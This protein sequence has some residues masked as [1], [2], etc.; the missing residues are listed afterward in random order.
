MY[1]IILHFL[2]VIYFTQ[3]SKIKFKEAL[4]LLFRN[5]LMQAQAPIWFRLRCKNKIRTT[6]DVSFSHV[7]VVQFHRFFDILWII[8]LFWIFME[9]PNLKNR[10]ILGPNVF[11]SG[12]NISLEVSFIVILTNNTK[13]KITMLLGRF[14]LIFYLNYEHVLFKTEKK[15][16]VDFL[17][18]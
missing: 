4:S 10:T 16:F 6:F 11:L 5:K 2:H 1:H 17:N 14:A 9:V 12:V 7:L 8:L 3:F 13:F 18:F 15:K